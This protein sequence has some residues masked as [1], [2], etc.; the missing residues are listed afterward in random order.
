MSVESKW[1]WFGRAGHFIGGHDCLF[2]L[3]TDVGHYLVL[4]VGDYRPRRAEGMGMGSRMPD[5]AT[6]LGA[7]PDR[8][9]TYVFRKKKGV[10]DC[11]CGM[12]K[13]D[14]SEIDG[15]LVDSDPAAVALHFEMCRKYAAKR[16]AKASHG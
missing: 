10:C 14:L 15:T 2:H 9:E 13:I 4:T 1:R 5:K 7:G 3:C 8:Y 16:K 6:P 12:P 11:G